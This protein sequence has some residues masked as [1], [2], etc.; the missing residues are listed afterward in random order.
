MAIDML[1]STPSVSNKAHSDFILCQNFMFRLST[2][3]GCLHQ[4]LD[5]DQPAI[6]TVNFKSYTQNIPD[7]DRRLFNFL[8]TK[9]KPRPIDETD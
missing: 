9:I 8:V 6:T 4:K 7:P 2:V 5:D 3:D 1:T